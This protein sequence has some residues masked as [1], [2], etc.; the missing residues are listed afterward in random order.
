MTSCIIILLCAFLAL[1]H[2][3]LIIGV[4]SSPSEI[5]SSIR[6]RPDM[7][8][9]QQL[10]SQ[11]NEGKSFQRKVVNRRQFDAKVQHCKKLWAQS[12][13]SPLDIEVLVRIS[14][15]YYGP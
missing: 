13:Y 5:Y 9:C 3:D 7:A 1:S 4:S 11:L 15:Q 14:K 2:W 12:G 10:E 6:A 8:W